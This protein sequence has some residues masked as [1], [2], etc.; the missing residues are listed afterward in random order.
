[1]PN[2]TERTPREE[3][4]RK[5][6][7]SFLGGLILSLM[8]RGGPRE[9]RKRLPRNR[10][11]MMRNPTKAKMAAVIQGR[12]A[13]ANAEAARRLITEQHANWAVT[14]EKEALILT[15]IDSNEKELI[16]LPPDEAYA[17]LV[18]GMQWATKLSERPHR[19]PQ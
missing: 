13:P 2:Q 19:L 4:R 9:L 1:M 5:L 16:E 14:I 11:A 3:E 10:A 7:R 17:S 8:Q 15:W 12:P 18:A 6:A